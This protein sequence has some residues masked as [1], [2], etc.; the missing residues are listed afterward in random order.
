MI[1][2]S[3]RFNDIISIKFWQQTFYR[4]GMEFL[5]KF[6]LRA[7]LYKCGYNVIN[8]SLSGLIAAIRIP[9]SD[10]KA[11]VFP[12]DGRFEKKRLHAFLFMR[13]GRRNFRSGIRFFERFVNLKEK[14]N[15]RLTVGRLVIYICL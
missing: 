8:G 14:F 10:A 15:A 4:Y 1:F 12:F 2:I 6:I 11:D 3:L 5:K 9:L 7:L 13:C